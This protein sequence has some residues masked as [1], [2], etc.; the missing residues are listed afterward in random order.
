[1]EFSTFVITNKGQALMAKLM[2]G[3]GTCNFT[4][5]KLS[6]QEYTAAQLPTLTSLS[7]T[8]QTAPITRKTI[9]NTAS[10]QIEGAIDNKA[11][12][13]G[14]NIQSIG[15]FANDPDTGEILYAVAKATTPGYMPPY[16]GITV[17]GGYFKFVI[18]VGNATNVS[19]TVDPAGYASIGDVQSL[20]TEIS[21]L[22]GFVG[23]SDDDIYGV[24]VDFSNSKF[25][26]LAAAIGRNSGEG[27][28][29][30]EPF[31]GR[32]RCNLTDAG[33]EIAKYGDAGYSETGKLTQSITIGEAENAK[34]YPTG[35]IVQ[36]MVHQPKFYYKVVPLKT[37]KVEG[38]KGHHLRKA[39]Y[40]ISAAPKTGFKLHPAFI[41]NGV[42]KNYVY[43]SAYEGTLF[44]TSANAYIL[45]DAQ[46][47][48]F[49]ADKLCSIA[50]A[51]PISGT[52]QSLVRRNC[53][54]LAE[55][56]GKGWY[57]EYGALA[58]CTQLLF[59]VEYASFNTQSKIGN[60]VTGKPSIEE[61]VSYSENTGAS[62]PL[63]NASGSVT[64]GNG[65]NVV[66]YRGEENFWGNMW[67][68]VDGLNI[69]GSGIH[70]LYVA[71]HG[72]TESSITAPYENAGITLSKEN[73]YISAM[74]YSEKFD[75]LF[76][77]SETNHGANSSVPVGDYFYQNNAAA[78]FFVTFLGGPWTDGGD[79]G[80]FYW[81]VSYTP[82]TRSRNIGGRLAYVPGVTA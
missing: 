57:Q 48:D 35:T 44:D 39:R 56:R 20:Q 52:T 37:D 80:G 69:Q 2:Q 41:H 7:N 17:S 78:P 68:F 79:A 63:G 15:I 12:T 64:N 60:G 23:Y 82:S 25:S 10:I 81:D 29:S 54:L 77:P 62:T 65:F 67:K 28:D 50:N 46:V 59:L 31:G 45:D 13:V 36:V 21:D 66:S 76:F 5:I 11:L 4:A 72:F 3:N 14:Y 22:K 18:T 42:E 19:I 71:D 61:N 40:Y 8:K 24:E 34:T 27:F 33:E 53:G 1:M 47:A 9:V 43:M 75:W 51:K 58:A 30:V 55:K 73:G 26:R 49:A 38:G 74:A 32:Y 70:E 6:A 16:N